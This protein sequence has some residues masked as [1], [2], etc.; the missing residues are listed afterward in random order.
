MAETRHFGNK[1]DIYFSFYSSAKFELFFLSSK[2]SDVGFVA[3][4]PGKRVGVV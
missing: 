1:S 2:D 4:E 3:E